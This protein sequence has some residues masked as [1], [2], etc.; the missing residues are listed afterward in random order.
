MSHVLH[1]YMQFVPTVPAV[2]FI[3]LLNGNKVP[4]DDTKF[5]TKLLGGDQLTVVRVRSTQALC[6]TLDSAVE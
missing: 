2:G 1:H 4:F 3:V 6:D 5:D